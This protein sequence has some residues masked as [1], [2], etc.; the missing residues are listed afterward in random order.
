MLK[1]ELAALV[2]K[3]TAE[4][5]PK[6]N[7][8]DKEKTIRAIMLLQHPL[9]LGLTIKKSIMKETLMSNNSFTNLIH[10]HLAIC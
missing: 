6:H 7:D 2:R 3:I 8:M 4:L 5:A 1:S 10:K 9:E